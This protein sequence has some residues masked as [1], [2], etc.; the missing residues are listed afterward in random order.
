MPD[1]IHTLRDWS[2]SGYRLQSM[3]R[4]VERIPALPQDLRYTFGLVDCPMYAYGVRKAVELAACV[5]SNGVSLVEFGVGAGGGLEALSRHAR[6]YARNSGLSVHVFGFDS[7][8]GLPHSTDPRDLPYMWAQGQ[9]PM[10][11]QELLARLDGSAELMLGEVSE[12]V[13]A[14]LHTHADHLAQNPL[15]FISFDLDYYSSTTSA[16][17]VLR[18]AADEQLLPRVT[19]YFD[20]IL[21]IVEETGELAAIADFN[22]AEK[23]GYLGKV[24]A[25]RSHL[26][27]DPV[28]ADQIFQ[29]HRFSHAAYNRYETA[30]DSPTWRP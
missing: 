13:P 17:T 19:G 25:L 18:D 20:D 24:N 28:W 5:G 29:Y 27:F 1:L 2:M 12:T 15:G 10:Q 3:I 11:K 9:Y 30:R 22:R 7:G 26:P 16:L 8:S 23:A 4:A 21:S 14:F 6:Y